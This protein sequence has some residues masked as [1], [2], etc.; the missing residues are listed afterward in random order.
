MPHT[1]WSQQASY[2]EH[3]PFSEGHGIRRSTARWRRGKFS[4]NVRHTLRVED[5]DF[6]QREQTHAHPVIFGCRRCRK[7]ETRLHSHLSK[8]ISSNWTVINVLYLP[9][10]ISFAWLSEYYVISKF[11]LSYNGPPSHHQ[12]ANTSIMCF[13]MDI[14]HWNGKWLEGAD[15]W[16]SQGIDSYF[17]PLLMEYT[18]FQFPSFQ[19]PIP[20]NNR[21]KHLSPLAF[22]TQSCNMPYYCG[23]S[24]PER[25]GP[26]QI[27][28]QATAVLSALIIDN[29]HS[30]LSL[31]T[32]PVKFGAYNN[33]SV[34]RKLDSTAMH[35][36]NS[37]RFV[38]CCNLSCLQFQ[39]Y[40]SAHDLYEC[41]WALFHGTIDWTCV[42]HSAESTRDLIRASDICSTIHGY[43]IH[44]QRF[45]DW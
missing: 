21:R 43:I 42:F 44:S 6:C 18:V 15:F 27:D 37:A 7:N 41:S 2:F 12:I 20:C 3:R 26:Y 8:G 29:C 45:S 22:L 25:P 16:S 38:P 9:F 1:I 24:M 4:S 32:H 35:S 10:G 23:P 14:F 40:F 30:L 36:F 5:F 31:S 28:V 19:F 11:I 34:A 13:N 33:P 39:I 17:D